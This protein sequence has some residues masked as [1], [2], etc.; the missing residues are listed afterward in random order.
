MRVC[1]A[2]LCWPLWAGAQEWAQVALSRHVLTNDGVIAL[3]KAGFDETF[4]AERILTSR[5]RLDATV[6]GM[7]ALKKAG[8]TEDLIR[9][10]VWRESQGAEALVPVARASAAPPPPARPPLDAVPALVR[11]TWWG[12]RVWALP[13]APPRPAPWPLAITPVAVAPAWWAPL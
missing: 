7:L 2:V 3:A 9:V 5:T 1:L 6:D 12:Y 8:V 4:I 13:A 11:R 10:V